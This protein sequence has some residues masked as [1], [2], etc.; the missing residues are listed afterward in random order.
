MLAAERQTRL[1]QLIQQRFSMSVQ[2]L[3]ERFEVSPMTIRR[4]LGLLERKGLVVRIHGGAMAPE[5]PVSSREE[6]RATLRVLQ[7]VA[8]AAAAVRLVED[9]QTLFVDA[10]STTTELARRLRGHRGLTV[11][12][13]SVRV[14]TVLADSPGINLIGLGGT[15]Y[16][17][18]WSFVGPLAE[19]AL[20]RFNADLTFL[21]ISSVSLEEGLSEVN[22]FEAAIKSLA[23]Q[24]GQRVVLLADST[25]FEKVSPVSVAP[26]HEVDVVI[27][28]DQLPSELVA[29][30]RKA[31]PEVIL[32]SEEG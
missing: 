4:D 13:N 17:G 8:I 16:R 18:A 26:L 3:S 31:G 12:T 30:Y 25:K 11:V 20:R 32:V 7:K 23:I 21:G 15:V 6:V 9:G 14:L 28:D 29:A 22:F 1:A 2:E 19:A 24:Q 5:T 10:G 27:T